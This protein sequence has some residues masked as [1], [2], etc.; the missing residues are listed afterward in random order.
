MNNSNDFPW[1]ALVQVRVVVH[2]SVDPPGND[3]R[4]EHNMSLRIHWWKCQR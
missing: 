3:I 1:T 2:A 4:M